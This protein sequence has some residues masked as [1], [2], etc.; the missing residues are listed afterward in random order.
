[1]WDEVL[2]NDAEEWI[3]AGDEVIAI[4]HVGVR[5]RRSGIVV[6]RR[7]CHVWTLRERKLWRLRIYATKT[8]SLE[9]VGLSE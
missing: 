5:G 7:E 4:M 9:A 3:D 2:S 8:E 1:V 6:E